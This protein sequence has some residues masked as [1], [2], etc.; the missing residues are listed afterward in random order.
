[1]ILIY[2]DKKTPRLQYI[3]NQLFKHVLGYVFHVTDKKDKYLSFE[4]ACLCYSKTYLG[5]GVHIVPQGL[6]EEDHLHPLDPE[7]SEW[8]G[9]PVFFRTDAGDI[10]FDMFS[11]AFYLVSRYEEYTDKE[12]DKHGRY[13]AENSLAYCH[14]F[15]DRPI[16][17]EWTMVLN[18]FIQKAYPEENRIPQKFVYIPTI[19][20]DHIYAFL[21]KGPIVNGYKIIKELRKGRFKR[22]LYIMKVLL[23]LKRDPFFNFNHLAYLHEPCYRTCM[24]FCH[25][26]CHGKY[27]KRTY[28]PSIKY[29]LKKRALSRNITMGLHPSYHAGFSSIRFRLEKW[30]MSKSTGEPVIANRFHYLRFRL[31]DSYDMLIR[32]NIREDWS[33]TY[34]DFPGFRA[35]TSFPFRFYNLK[36][37]KTYKL[38]VH[39]TTVMDKT[40]K[41]NLG[42]SIDESYDYIITM[43]KKVEAVNGDFVTIFHNDHLTDA[44]EEWR[45]WTELYKRVLSHFYG[46]TFVDPEQND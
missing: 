25:C 28:V 40:L 32:N 6:L 11:A 8:N 38:I 13:K 24:A 36:N 14:G 34:S 10:L 30:M 37:E 33:M 43:A 23:R 39:P 19:D 29:F 3:C 27:D 5:K 12:T 22:A 7:V 9:L 16:V 42:L 1:M 4:G 46:E 21:H 45:G 20:I 18:E 41:S 31:P 15:L 26:G 17:D 2:A 44:F 35:G